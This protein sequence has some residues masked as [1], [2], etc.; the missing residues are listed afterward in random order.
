MERAYGQEQLDAGRKAAGYESVDQ[1]DDAAR[2]TPEKAVT[3]EPKS[4]DDLGVAARRV[5][6]LPDRTQFG[7]A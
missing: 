6:A 5:D 2:G 1:A 7:Q 4:D 3:R